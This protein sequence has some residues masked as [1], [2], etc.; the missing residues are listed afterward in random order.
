MTTKHAVAKSATTKY[1]TMIFGLLAL[2]HGS[3][4]LAVNPACKVGL[5]GIP[6]AAWAGMAISSGIACLVISCAGYWRR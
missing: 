4:S 3:V 2:L 6:E 5:L 1:F